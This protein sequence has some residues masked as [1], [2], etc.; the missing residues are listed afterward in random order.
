[1]HG[2]RSRA[3]RP[4]RARVIAFGGA[5]VAAA[6]SLLSGDGSPSQT[7]AAGS[8]PAPA[9][10]PGFPRLFP[11]PVDGRPSYGGL[12]TASF[13]P[14]GSESLVAS[15]P[16]GV[17][18]VVDRGGTI[19]PGWPHT[20]AALPQPAY[21]SGAAAVGDVDGDGV[22]EIA[23]CVVSG[24]WPRDAWVFVWRA[25]GTDLPG[26]PRY[27]PQ[28]AASS[29]CSPAPVLLRDLDADGRAEVLVASA[30]GTLYAL[31]AAG[32]TLPGWPYRLPADATGRV[33]PINAPLAAA[34]VDGDGRDDLLAVE[35][36][37][38]PRLVALRWDGTPIAPFPV[39]FDQVVGAQAPAAGDVDGDGRAE[40]LQATQPFDGGVHLLDAAGL[41]STDPA[42]GVAAALHLLRHDGLE[43]AGW[44]FA[45]GSAAVH[46]ALVADVDGD[47][48]LDVIQGEGDRIDV[49]DAFGT[50]KAGFPLVLH[51]PIPHTQ[52]LTTSQVLVR[53]VDRDGS[54]D[55]LIAEGALE[56]TGT[57]LARLSAFKRGGQPVAGF[58][59][60]IDGVQP[61]SD[62]VLLDLTGDGRPD[63]ALLTQEA[64][65]GGWRLLAWDLAAPRGRSP[66][67]GPRTGVVGARPEP[68]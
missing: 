29:G 66:L 6:G 8:R 38:R 56:T 33:R 42:P 63:P 60:S 5:I 25:D 13:D 67:V 36:G 4:V 23:A 10:A 24:P 26:W 12:V 54:V 30:T 68:R 3:C 21:P 1:M 48:V 65:N 62:P 52:T 32:G 64:G 14:D 49:L 55:F 2:L 59:F 45:L 18:T 7:F 57:S 9:Y 35:S 41:L 15:V 27:L 17:V 19:R 43:G 20:F 46:G 34:D 61:A 44:P 11:R 39:T 22:P 50:M 58:P 51:R 47:G 37:W 28:S 31:D 16:S 53:D 40:V